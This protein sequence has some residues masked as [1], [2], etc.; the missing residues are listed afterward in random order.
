M[1]ST[2]VVTLCYGPF[3]REEILLKS[4]YEKQN[5]WKKIDDLAME[6][7]SLLR[8]LTFAIWCMLSENCNTAAVLYVYNNSK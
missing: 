3:E 5:P 8:N 6:N 4:I 1:Q 7:W 2:T